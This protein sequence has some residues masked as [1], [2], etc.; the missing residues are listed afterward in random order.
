MST[1]EQL[2]T[3]DE[4]LR[5]P[6]DGFRYELVKGELR[7]MAPAGHEHGRVAVRFTWRLAHYVETNNLGVV[8]AAETGF[9]LAT[10]PDTVRAPDVAF[11]SRERLEA[12]KST[13]GFF[14]GA[15]D[16]AVEV[17]SPGDTYT[18]V[19]EKAMDWLAAGARMVLALNSRKRTVTVFRSLNDIVILGDDA[20]LD[21][22]DVVPG[23]KIAVKDI[24]D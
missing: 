21:L 16:L 5:M 13:T 15:P 1:T 19:E 3:A 14:P 7:K 18:E 12:V 8:Y 23:F 17:V 20:I 6:D 4:L 22:D 11:V 9:R 24:F 10:D 2:M